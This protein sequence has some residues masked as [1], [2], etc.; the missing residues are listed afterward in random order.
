M[1]IMEIEVQKCGV[2]FDPPA[3]M[4]VYSDNGSK[5][6][7]QRTMPLRDFT[8]D[9]N[10][11]KATDDLIAHP[12]HGKY[13]TKI[14]KVQLMRLITIIRDKL[15][16]MSL[17]ASLAR[18][19]ALDKIDPEENL[20]TVDEETLKRKKAAMERTF[21]KHQVKPNDP[22]FKY[23]VDVEFDE[24]DVIESG[25]DSGEDGSDLEF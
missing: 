8:K 6:H 20:N 22:N 7:R 18:N 24:Q 23:D 9:S 2:K 1:V 25:W 3:I 21:E 15:N 10:T 5:K 4:I 19:D 11:E 16:G 14:P 17:E 12:R 13:V